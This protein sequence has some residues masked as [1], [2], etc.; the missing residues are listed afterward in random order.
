MEHSREYKQE[1][2]Y[3]RDLLGPTVSLT[4]AAFTPIP[5]DTSQV[6]ERSWQQPAAPRL[7]AWGWPILDL[8]LQECVFVVVQLIKLAYLFSVLFYLFEG[9]PKPSMH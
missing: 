9:G 4:Q 7:R 1:R 8:N 2:T 5:V 6:S 3:T